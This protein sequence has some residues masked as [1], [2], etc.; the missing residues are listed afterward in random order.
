M[1]EETVFA[2]N[3]STSVIFCELFDCREEKGGKNLGI[4]LSF[5]CSL[6]PFNTFPSS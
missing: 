6:M 5:R 2:T 3:K 1:L 4:L